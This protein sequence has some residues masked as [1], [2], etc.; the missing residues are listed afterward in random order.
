MQSWRPPASGTDTEPA[1]GERELE[2]DVSY[3]LAGPDDEEGLEVSPEEFLLRAGDHA[4][5]FILVEFGAHLFAV[6]GVPG[7]GQV[8]LDDMAG[9]AQ[10]TVDLCQPMPLWAA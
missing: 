6:H 4:E 8:A 1:R 9:G 2:L 10:P 7:P 3:Y 5:P